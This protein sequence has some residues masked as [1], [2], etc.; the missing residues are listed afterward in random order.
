MCGTTCM[1]FQMSLP[2]VA[3]ASQCTGSVK[4]IHIHTPLLNAVT[5]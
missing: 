4:P 5:H 3:N 2:T 1:H